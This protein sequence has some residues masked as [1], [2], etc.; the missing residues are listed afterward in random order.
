MAFRPVTQAI[1]AAAFSAAAVMFL[2]AP[3][4]AQFFDDRFPFESRPR[5]SIF[6][7]PPGF[8]GAPPPPKP[9]DYS[10]APAPK[11]YDK[12]EGADV[13]TV[14]V[15]GDSMADW[16]G[17]GLEQAFADSPEL[18][19]VR[20]PRA[21]SSLIN[22]PG[23]HDVRSR[24]DWPIAAQEILSKESPAFVVMMIGLGDREP[25]RDV[26]PPPAKPG[27]EKKGSAQT[28]AQANAAPA[29]PGESKPAATP[30]ANAA[31]TEL[32]NAALRPSVQEGDA[33][34][35][36]PPEAEAK[37]DD[38]D[39][40]PN[41]DDTPPTSPESA[42]NASGAYEFKTEKWVEL[43]AKRVDETI[44]ALKAKGVPVF[45]VGLPP[46]R[47]ARSMSEVAF[48]NEI[49][50]SRA[51]KAG[52]TYIDVWDGFVDEGNRFA[53]QG[54]DF[55]GQIRK[56]RTP[57]GVHFTQPGARKLAHY[58]DKEI[59]RAMT[60]TGPVA[61][62]IPVD[63]N[64]AQPTIGTAPT[65]GAVIARP[66]AGP[67]IPLNASTDNTD[68]DELAGA[69]GA[70]Q[71]LT[72]A[73]ATR[74]LVRGEALPVPAGRADDFVWPRRAPAPLGAD[75]VVATTTLPMTPMVAE[76]PPAPKIA[77]VPA[78][79]RQARAAPRPP[80]A[81]G[82]PGAS[83]QAQAQAQAQRD[84]QNRRGPPPPFFFFFNR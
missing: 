59:R 37:T 21:Y 49:F 18:T 5:G 81:V 24:T 53:Q 43:Y 27:P 9:V 47:G 56:L 84:A 15:L 42:R 16:L 58:V 63:P 6:G 83:A 57:D 1:G 55:E 38:P 32:P 68:S 73:A 19:V 82:P 26:R 48:L 31:A 44:A 7:P 71:S 4:M 78:A 80:G 51:E 40:P 62:P 11:K 79:A 65:P 13:S 10:R 70:R 29:K 20:K 17:Y 61:I 74:V 69:T 50:R 14:L 23:R 35:S 36:E 77:A 12:N 33:K 45:W 34:K 41:V 72:D 3:A 28:P 8:P 76:R 64:A 54:P 52:I 39:A 67:V 2:L 66:L 30:P 46:V 25:I 75:P 60:P 22:S